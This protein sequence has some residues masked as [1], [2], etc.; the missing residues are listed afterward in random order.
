M[1]STCA[2]SS[3]DRAGDRTSRACRAWGGVS[4]PRL[5]LVAALG[6]S[7]A[8]RA[9]PWTPPP[10]LIQEGLRD[11]VVPESEPQP[12]AEPRPDLSASCDPDP[13]KPVALAWENRASWTG[14]QNGVFEVRGDGSRFCLVARRQRGLYATLVDVAEVTSVVALVPRGRNRSGA[15]DAAMTTVRV[16]RDGRE[17]ESVFPTGTSG[18]VFARGDPGL[19]PVF[20]RLGAALFALERQ[21]WKVPYRLAVPRVLRP[22]API[23]KNGATKLRVAIS[24]PGKAPITV[25][26]TRGFVELFAGPN[27]APACLHCPVPETKVSVTARALRD[28]EVAPGMEREVTLTAYLRGPWP[29]RVYAVVNGEGPAAA[30]FYVGRAGSDDL[31]IGAEA[32]DAE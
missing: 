18:G 10:A 8:P 13:T 12:M 5:L 31:V 22:Q 15:R 26:G 21:A 3:D 20:G 17:D 14:G 16:Q 23:A 1:L 32:R 27:I 28:L 30:P 2:D 7:C 19:A 6:T 11:P 9:A 4:A 24:N 25:R 29:M